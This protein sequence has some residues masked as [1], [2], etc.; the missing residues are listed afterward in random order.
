MRPELYIRPCWHQL[1]QLVLNC[2]S[3]RVYIGGTPGCSKSCFGDFLFTEL[4]NR[5]Y[6]VIIQTVRV[7]NLYIC[8]SG[9][10]IPCQVGESALFKALENIDNWYICDGVKPFHAS[11]RSVLISS[12]RESIRKEFMKWNDNP[13]KVVPSL[14]ECFYMPTWSF[15]ELIECRERCYPDININDVRSLFAKWGGIPRFVFAD[16]G[17]DD[18]LN[19]AISRT[20]WKSVEDNVGKTGFPQEISHKI[21]HLSVSDD[22]KHSHCFC[23]SLCFSIGY[24]S[25]FETGK[26]G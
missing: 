16:N 10:V 26:E 3:P 17:S 18:G 23:F 11:A 2:E 6:T 9:R 25:T 1:L 14:P 24:G 7:P 13:R 8:Q 19:T 22:L 15:S 20:N 5:N 12:P 4:I 21:V